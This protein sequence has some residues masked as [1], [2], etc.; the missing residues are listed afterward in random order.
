MIGDSVLNK[1]SAALHEQ[2]LVNSRVLRGEAA[3]ET[4][5]QEHKKKPLL[6]MKKLHFPFETHLFSSS[7]ALAGGEAVF[8]W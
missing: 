8:R 7:I 1:A 2:F 6:P 5:A 4:L 3:V